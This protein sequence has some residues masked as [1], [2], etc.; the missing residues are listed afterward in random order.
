MKAVANINRAAQAESAR[1]DRRVSR[2][3]AKKNDE[4]IFVIAPI[5]G[6]ANAIA[7]LLTAHGFQASVCEDL[8]K[9]AVEITSA[10]AL[11]M[12]EEALEFATMTNLLFA[13]DDQPPWSEL[14]VIIL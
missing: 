10:G 6:D 12:T 14:P 11:V 1:R 8:A 5:G 13:L 4:R 3:V 7:S 2:M 9:S